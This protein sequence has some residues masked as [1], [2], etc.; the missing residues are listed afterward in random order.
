[1]IN[2]PA[3]I[4]KRYS[5]KEG[6]KIIFV[7]NED[8]RLELI[9]VPKLMDLFGAGYEQRRELLSGIN[10]LE[11]EHRR[12]ARHDLNNKKKHSN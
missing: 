2:I 8:G 1:M 3:K 4:R 11:S 12:E 5:I 10:E 6:S 9:P 7:E